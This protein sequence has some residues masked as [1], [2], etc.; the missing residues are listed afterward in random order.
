M[1]QRRRGKLA[2]NS[3]LAILVHWEIL[4]ESSNRQILSFTRK[5]LYFL[6]IALCNKYII[7]K[8]DRNEVLN[9]KIKF[10]WML[11]NLY[12]CVI[13]SPQDQ[14]Q[15]NTV[16][17]LAIKLQD[18]YWSNSIQ[19]VN[20]KKNC[21]ALIWAKIAFNVLIFVAQIVFQQKIKWS[22]FRW[23]SFLKTRLS[24]MLK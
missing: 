19:M 11:L 21:L 4:D 9:C 17:M 13:V 24:I 22:I 3:K 15:F 14:F 1:T 12:I 6:P 8:L 16:L 23:Q 20:K 18:Y 10:S 2:E 5:K 7:Q